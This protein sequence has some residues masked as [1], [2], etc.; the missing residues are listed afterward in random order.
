MSMLCCSPQYA[1][2]TIWLFLNPTQ[3]KLQILVN[4]FNTHLPTNMYSS[5]LG[6]QFILKGTS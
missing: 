2:A 5:A 3:L 6:V 1:V 4:T